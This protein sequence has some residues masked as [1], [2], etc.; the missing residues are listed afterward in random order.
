MCGDYTT[1]PF[2]FPCERLWGSCPGAQLCESL[3]CLPLAEGDRRPGR[4]LRVGE[5]QGSAQSCWMLAQGWW[6][7]GPKALSPPCSLV[8]TGTSPAW[9]CGPPLALGR[10]GWGSPPRSAPLAGMWIG[11]LARVEVEGG[12]CPR[13]MAFLSPQCVFMTASPRRGSTT[14]SS[15]CKCQ[16]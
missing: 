2:A 15:I 11:D 12:L 13:L 7:A 9:S 5:G 6:P 8:A 14:W 10:V 16:S 1:V 3:L 4:Q